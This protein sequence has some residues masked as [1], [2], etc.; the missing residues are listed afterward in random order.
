MKKRY[1]HNLALKK[2][3]KRVDTFTLDFT[4]KV[5][6]FTGVYPFQVSISAS[7]L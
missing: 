2:I 4:G 3:K 6:A 1:I 7:T 5:S